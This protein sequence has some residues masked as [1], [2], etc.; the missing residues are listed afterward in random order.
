MKNGAVKMKYDACWESLN[1]RPVPQWFGEAKFGIFIHWGLYSVPAYTR[2]GEYAEWYMKQIENADHPTRIFHDRTYGKNFRYEDFVPMFKAELFDA[3]K[4]ADL[5]KKSGAKYLNFV[6]KHHDGY[7]LYKTPYAYNWNTADVG[8]HR[9]FLA[10]MKQSMEGTGVKFGVYHSVYEWFH[11]LYLK[12]PEEYATEH[13]IPMLKDLIERYQPWTLFTDGEWDHPSN[14]WH[15]T[16]FLQWLFNESS[17]KDTIVVND[18]W[19]SETRGVFGGNYTTEY[20]EVGFGKKLTDFSRPFEECRGIGKSFG[21]NRIESAEDYMSAKELLVTLCDLVSKGGNFLLNIGPAA[22]GTIPAIMEERL[23][24]MGSWLAVNGEAI[25]SS[26]VYDR[27]GEDGVYY[28]RNHG[29]VYAILDQ[30]PFA[31]RVLEKVP[32][33][34]KLTAQILGCETAP[35]EVRNNHGRAELVF[36][37]IN[38]DEMGS[39]WLYTVRLATV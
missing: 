13:L 7:C 23:L 24:Q 38:P 34:E 26:T 12:N 33:S 29:N 16:E 5:F 2:N 28:T 31:S 1:S 37:F 36:P 35:V 6:S 21:F 10:E 18:R 30:Y 17:V 11:P 32:Y 20:G 4:W 27:E 14:V 15:S 8:P 3:D 19:G 9:D 22:D 25:Y 39:Q